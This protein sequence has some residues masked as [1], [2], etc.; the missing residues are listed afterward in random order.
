M[1]RKPTILELFLSFEGRLPRSGF[2]VGFAILLVIGVGVTI[3]KGVFAGIAITDA[4]PWWSVGIGFVLMRLYAPLLVKRLHDRGRSAW[5]AV[6]AVSAWAFSSAFAPWLWPLVQDNGRS[7]V[8]AELSIV[9]WVVSGVGAG[10]SLWLLVEAGLLGPRAS[11]AK[12]ERSPHAYHG[13]WRGLAECVGAWCLGVLLALLPG[14]DSE[15][16]AYAIESR[17]E[18]HLSLPATADAEARSQEFL[19]EMLKVDGVAS[20]SSRMGRSGA[21]YELI[22]AANADAV[23][24]A[25]QLEILA[26][27]RTKKSGAVMQRGRLRWEIACD[28][29]H[30]IHPFVRDRTRTLLLHGGDSEANL[31]ALA[32]A[33]ERDPRIAWARIAGAPRRIQIVAGPEERLRAYGLTTVELDASVR[34]AVAARDGPED[35]AA[36]ETAVVA[37]RDGAVVRVAD[38]C[39]VRTEI[40]WP[41]VYLP[42][43]RGGVVRIMRAADASWDEVHAVVQ[44][45]GSPLADRVEMVDETSAGRRAALTFSTSRDLPAEAFL[46]EVGQVLEWLHGTL[47]PQVVCLARCRGL[48]PGSPTRARCEIEILAGGNYEWQVTDLERKLKAFAFPPGIDEVEVEVKSGKR[49]ELRREIRLLG[50]DWE[51]LQELEQGVRAALDAIEGM[52]VVGASVLRHEADLAV[53]FDREK[54]RALGISIE[55]A[56]A[57]VAVAL[58][59]ASRRPSGVQEL[60]SLKLITSSGLS[61]PFADVAEVGP[62]SAL[63]RFAHLGVHRGVRIRCRIEPKA[64]RAGVDLRTQQALAALRASTPVEIRYSGAA[65][66]DL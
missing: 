58:R 17:I 10:G 37:S 19:G 36:I 47:P 60:L 40:A 65:G 50:E 3:A 39:E 14:P 61:V 2:W 35:I 51:Q 31:T 46:R 8:T 7:L 42:E 18:I 48:A 66:S 5:L 56:E 62:S 34:Q 57:Q 13:H 33:F 63:V 55:Q 22:L 49:L 11:G 26:Q 45:L 21:S 25:K 6:V 29:L 9:A 30:S 4:Q 12:Y 28:A 20:I 64:S 41:H 23:A 43:H 16:F 24:I 52:Q 59:A 15:F 1:S 38:L 54:L 32:D 27:A 53:T 44:R